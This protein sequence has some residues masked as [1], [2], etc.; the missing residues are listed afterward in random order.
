MQAFAAFVVVLMLTF[1]DALVPAVMH[2]ASADP[3]KPRCL[4]LY[5]AATRAPWALATQSDEHA[6]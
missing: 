1:S 2:E 4:Q 5:V 3:C 6:L